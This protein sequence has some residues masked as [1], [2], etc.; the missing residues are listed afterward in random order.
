MPEQQSA[1]S[2]NDGVRQ[3]QADIAAD[4]RDREWVEY[5]AGDGAGGGC[6]EKVSV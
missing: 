2:V 3:I 1:A 6:W 4:Y 5:G